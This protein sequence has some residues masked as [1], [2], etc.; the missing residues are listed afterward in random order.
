MSAKDLKYWVTKL[1]KQNMPAVGKI[2]AELNALAGSEESEINQLAEVILRDPNLT[3]H[4]LRVSNSVFY[5]YSNTPINTV[6]RAIVLIGF[7]GMRAVCISLLMIDSLLSKGPKERLLQLMAQGLHAATHARDLI[8]LQDEDSAEEVFIAALLYNLGE[9]AFLANE[10]IDD[11]DIDILDANAKVRGEAMERVL[12]TSFKAITRA[13]TKHWSLGPILEQA[14][15][16][17][18]L[19]SNNVQAVLLGERMSR[20]ALNGWDSPHV[21]KIIEEMSKFS[22]LDSSKCLAMSQESAERAGDIALQYGV[23]DACL[24]IPGKNMAGKELS[25]IQV[26]KILRGDPQLQLNILRE[27]T[28]ATNEKT[29]VNT[30]FQMVLEG[31]HRGIGLERVAVAFLMRHSAK[32]KYVLGEGTDKWRTGF[33]FDVG[34][35][36]DNVFTMAIESGDGTWVDQNFLDKNK[37]AF[38]SEII[39]VLGERQCFIFVLHLGQRVPA[40]FYADRGDFGGKLSQD[41]YDAFC[42]FAT[43]AQMSLNTISQVNGSQKKHEALVG[44]NWNR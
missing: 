7:K 42:Y 35:Y 34:P 3:S 22:N 38:T 1:T 20:A 5:N 43:Q 27:L 11:K 23:A 39:R 29:D 25:Q 15:S 6:S 17:S 33:D 2:I 40:F 28:S 16:Q 36:S 14:L 18:S 21:A 31:M 30:I 41:Q 26:H 10:T 9:M 37:Q 19:P 24:L 12:G 32:A 4:V 44:L 8:M 13:L